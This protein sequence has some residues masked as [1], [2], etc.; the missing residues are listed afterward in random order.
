MVV[1]VPQQIGQKMSSPANAP[2]HS[3]RLRKTRHWPASNNPSIRA[4]T[5]KAIEYFSSSPRAAIT[6]NPSQYCA[7]P[8]LTARITQEAQP[9][10]KS[11]SKQLVPSRLPLEILGSDQCGYGAEQNSE[12]PTPQ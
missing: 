8:R 2:H 10:H 12:S 4:K 9:V 1:N 11:G 5:N 7:A 3:Q 6:P